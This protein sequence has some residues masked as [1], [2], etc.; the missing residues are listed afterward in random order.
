V[1]AVL[2]CTV[3]HCLPG[4]D[5]EIV[6][7]RLR[8]VDTS[9]VPAAPARLLPRRLHLAGL[10]VGEHDAIGTICQEVTFTEFLLA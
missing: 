6:I 5:H 10:P 1:L 3:E 2:E 7:G 8:H 4:G 9:T